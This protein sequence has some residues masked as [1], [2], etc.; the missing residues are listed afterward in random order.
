MSHENE[1]HD[2]LVTMLEIIWGEG[3]MAPGGPGNVERLLDGI[4]TQDRQILDIGCGIGGP[5][6][7]MATTHGA[8]VTG[9]D[10]ESPLIERAQQRAV[11]LGLS[12]RCTFQTVE[13]GPLPFDDHSFDVVVSSGAFTQISD[14][15]GILGESLRVLRPGGYL[16]CYDWLGSGREHSD[17]MRYWF[18]ME[19]I[20][21]ALETL[22]SYEQHLLDAGFVHISTTDAS[23][24]Y[25]KEAHREYDLM[26]G[27][28]FP[29][30]V[31]LLGQKD[32]DYFVE[33][34]RSMVVVIDQG[35]MR[36]GYCRARRPA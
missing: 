29:R 16:R 17:D 32:A 8:E 12:D 5:A 3:Y 22:E 24:W 27:E 13:V 31:E 28:L 30:M 1:Y 25:R 23:D 11:Q 26:R 7:E 35:D 36:Q 18:K 2:N 9:I 20:T 6:I 10:L 21:Y 19:G 14:K 15:S 33:N 34:W 4:D